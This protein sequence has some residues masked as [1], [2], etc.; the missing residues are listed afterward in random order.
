MSIPQTVNRPPSSDPGKSVPSQDQTTEEFRRSSLPL[1]DV[2][3]RPTAAPVSHA[4]PL[5]SPQELISRHPL[6]HQAKQWVEGHRAR[7]RERLVRG[8]GAPI[9]IVGPCSIHCEKAV[10]EYGEKLSKLQ[11]RLGDRVI[12]VMRAYFEKPRTTIGWKGF[13]YDPD[14]NGSDDLSRGLERAR[15]LLVQLSEMGLALATEILDPLTAPYFQD[16]LSWV[17]IGAR[18]SESQIHRQLASGLPCPVGFK[19]GTDGSLS[20]AVQAMQSAANPHTHLG[21]DSAGRA[22]LIKSPGNAH[23]HLVLRGGTTGPN[24]DERS[25]ELAGESLERAGMRPGVL[26]DCSHANSEKDH[27]NQP[28]VARHVLAQIRNAAEGQCKNV[29]LLGLMIESH[30]NEGQQS[31]EEALEYGVSI[32]D[33]CIDFRTTEVILEELALCVGPA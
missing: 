31:T 7:L 10:V 5:P 8:S 11:S 21:I 23:T 6:S 26:V 24:Y 1:S 27:R 12:V 19:N 18:T 15:A 16:C 2:A 9:V 20:V 4:R 3:P 30:L 28:K 22:A 17:A 29:D 33:A 25:I 32:T 13:L 14:V